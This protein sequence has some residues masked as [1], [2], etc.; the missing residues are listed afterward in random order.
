[1]VLSW[2]KFPN[3]TPP[4]EL[5]VQRVIGPPD[6]PKSLGSAALVPLLELIRPADLT[7]IPPLPEVMLAFRDVVPP[8]S[9]WTEPPADEV[10][11]TVVLLEDRITIFET[12][13]I[14]TV[15]TVLAVDST[16]TEPAASKAPLPE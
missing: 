14:A 9:T 2:L 5:V 12:A 6:V 1:M 15:L 3:A 4:L 7:R 8:D 16:D 13:A 10:P 11:P